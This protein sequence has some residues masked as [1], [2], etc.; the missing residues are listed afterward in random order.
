VAARFLDQANR[1]Y[2]SA[3]K[4]LATVKKLLRPLALAA[5][6]P[7]RITKSSNGKSP[8]SDRLTLF[9]KQACTVN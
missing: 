2:L 4:T 8:G 9:E 6:L 5:V 3:I 7:T 1:R